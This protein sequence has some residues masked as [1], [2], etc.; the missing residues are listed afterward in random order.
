MRGAATPRTRCTALPGAHGR[1][2][3]A[4]MPDAPPCTVVFD[5]DGTLVD[6]APDLHAA[7]DRMVARLGRHGFRRAEVTAMIG[8]GV[9]FDL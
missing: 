4:H 3:L 5:L 7:L 8:D 6:S 2:T 9:R 1:A